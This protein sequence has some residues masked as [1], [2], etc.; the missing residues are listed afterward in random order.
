[1][2][3]T[4]T[5]TIFK[6]VR[7]KIL[8]IFSYKDCLEMEVASFERLLNQSVMKT[9]CPPPSPTKPHPPKSPFLCDYGTCTYKKYI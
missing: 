8:G 2:S 1:M 3:G 9:P 4:P 5:E 7:K 6:T